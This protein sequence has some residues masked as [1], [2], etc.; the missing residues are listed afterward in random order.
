MAKTRVQRVFSLTQRLAASSPF[1]ATVSTAENGTKPIV[2]GQDALAGSA[3][4]DVRVSAISGTL[5]MSMTGSFD[6]SNFFA[7]TPTSAWSSITT[8]THTSRVYSGPLPPILKVTQTIAGTV[9]ASNDVL[10]SEL[11]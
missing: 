6:G 8:T 10:L 11:L 2:A 1:T 5:D 9:T 3:L 4:L 7:L